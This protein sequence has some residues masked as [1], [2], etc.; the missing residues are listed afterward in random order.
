MEYSI[1]IRIDIK[2]NTNHIELENLIYDCGYNLYAIN[3]FNDFDLDGRNKYIKN[4]NKVIILEFDEENNLLNFIKFIKK[5][6]KLDIEYI[7]EKNNI[8][9]ADNK[10]LNNIDYDI[11][12]KLDYWQKESLDFIQ[13]INK[14]NPNLK[15]LS[16]FAMPHDF[17]KEDAYK[18]I[19]RTR[20][21]E[22]LYFD[23]LFY[24]GIPEKDQIDPAKKEMKEIFNKYFK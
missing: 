12:Q 3:I 5:M 22:N 17:S 10:Y 14:I 11:S 2:K 8:I 7:Y 6:K 21:P 19:S 1:S 24:K 23:F 13:F 16:L 4:N 20:K 18:L 9:Y 15:L